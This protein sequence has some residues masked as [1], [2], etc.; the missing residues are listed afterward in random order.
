MH[1]GG[2]DDDEKDETGKKKSY[3]EIVKEIITKSKHHKVKKEKEN[4]FIDL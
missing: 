3:S 2:F 4:F 1:F